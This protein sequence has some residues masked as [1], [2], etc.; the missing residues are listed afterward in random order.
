VNSAY[1]T[2]EEADIVADLKAGENLNTAVQAFIQ[3]LTK[4]VRRD[5]KRLAMGWTT[6][7][8]EFKSH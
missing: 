7:G 6:E 4:P 2:F 5:S 3:S 1:P 8:L